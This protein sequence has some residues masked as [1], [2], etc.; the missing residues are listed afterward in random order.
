MPPLWYFSR[1][2]KKP[3]ERIAAPKGENHGPLA[4]LPCKSAVSPGSDMGARM[5]SWTPPASRAT[6]RISVAAVMRAK[7][8]P[9]TV[10]RQVVSRQLV[11]RGLAPT[12]RPKK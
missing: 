6:Y 11:V 1:L 8:M 4:V 7:A 2:L 10:R 3:D 5:C 9:R 12:A